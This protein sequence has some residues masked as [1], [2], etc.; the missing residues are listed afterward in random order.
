MPIDPK[1]EAPLR[2][3]IGHVM[4]GEEDELAE[5]VLSVGD[6]VYEAAA[7]LSIQAA[8]YIAVHV[9]GRW[10]TDADLAAIAKRAARPY[11]TEDEIRR[12]F[13]RVVFHS[14]SPLGV[15]DDQKRA[16]MI[17]LFTLAGLLSA[18]G[19]KDTDQWG[20]LDQIW[21]AINAAESL[22][23]AVVPAVVYQFGRK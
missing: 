1:I 22:N 10:P 17:P 23:D 15:F 7:A 12:Y 14:E 6:Q 18:F 2:K 20:Y 13:A 4:R 16:A 3:M 8:G 9:S 5:L 21:N 19:P 11:V